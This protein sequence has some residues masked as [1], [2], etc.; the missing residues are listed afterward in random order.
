MLAT[1]RKSKLPK[2]LSY[3]IGAQ[4]LSAALEEIP[5]LEVVSLEFHLA[6]SGNRQPGRVSRYPVLEARYVHYYRPG[7]DYSPS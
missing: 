3:P 6:S 5:Q 7:R 2:S 4:V 1:T